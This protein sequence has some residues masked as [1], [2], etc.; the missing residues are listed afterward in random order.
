MSACVEI[1]HLRMSYA[2]RLVV[3][4]VSLRAP[5]SA[6]TVILGPNGAGKTTTIE[7]A[8]GFR[9][10]QSGEVTVLGKNPAVHRRE[11]AARVGVMLQAGGTWPSLRVEAMVDH[12]ARLYARPLPTQAL[13]E[14]L[15]LTAVART[16][17]RRLSGGEQRKLALACSL[18]GRPEVVFLDEPTT[19]LDPESR[20]AVWDLLREL[21]GC[22][23]SVVMS[24]HLLDEAQALADHVVVIDRGRVAASGSVAALTGAGGGLRFHSRPGLPVGELAGRLPPGSVCEELSSG[25]YRITGQAT[26]ELVA[27]VTAWC[28]E[29]GALPEHVSTGGESLAE[30]YFTITTA[31]PTSGPSHEAR[32]A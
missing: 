3:D 2:G 17:F 11:L 31:G 4:D 25:R 23:V 18:V 16:A 12:V 8:E 30:A 1:S 10:A 13:L 20:L 32:P 27:R 24:T 5:R 7:T 6:I 29:Q 15:G 19:G 21:R 9:R 22:A 26:P 28:A 14:R